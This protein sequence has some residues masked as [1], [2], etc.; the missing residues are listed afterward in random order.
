MRMAL[1]GRG[2]QGEGEG[3]AAA[4]GD[5]GRWWW[6]WGQ[7]GGWTGARARGTRTRCGGVG[8]FRPG[9]LSLALL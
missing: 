8:E 2:V 4:E 5:G 9:A 3:K 1:V 6:R 7:E